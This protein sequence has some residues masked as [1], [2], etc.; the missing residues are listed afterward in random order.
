MSI[1]GPP[2]TDAYRGLAELG[3]IQ[4]FL[5]NGLLLADTRGVIIEIS[6]KYASQSCVSGINF[7]K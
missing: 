7:V 2:F 5:S 4:A 6:K 3:I 1:M